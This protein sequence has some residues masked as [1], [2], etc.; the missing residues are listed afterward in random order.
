MDDRLIRTLRAT[1]ETIELSENT[2]C[3]SSN[4]VS[5]N[6]RQKRCFVSTGLNGVLSEFLRK[7]CVEGCVSW[8]TETAELRVLLDYHGIS[9]QQRGRPAMVFN[10]LTAA[11]IPFYLVLAVTVP[12][13]RAQAQSFDFDNGNAAVDIVIANVVPFIFE[14]ISKTAGDATLVLRTTTFLTNAWFDAT[15]P[16]HPTAVGVYSRLGRR[17]SSESQTNRDMNIAVVY[18]SY[19]VLLSLLPNRTQE[20]RQMLEN[21][22]LDPDD[23]RTELTSPVGIG[24]VAGAAIVTGRSR[25]GMNQLGD[26]DGRTF[27]LTP[28]ADYTGYRPLNTAYKLRRPSRWQPDLQVQGLG[29]YKIQQFVTPQYGL[30]E[31]YTYLDPR[32]F[33]VPPPI[34]S[35]VRRFKRY[36]R[37]ADEVLRASAELTEEQKLKAEFFDNKISSLGLSAVFAATSRQLPLLDFIHLDFMVNMAAFDAGIVIWQEKVR[38]DAVRPFSAIRYIYGDIPVKAWGGPFRG[39]VKIPANEWKS[40]LEEA[41]HPEYPSATTC[42]CAAHSQAARLILGDDELGYPVAFSAGTSR[43][44]PGQVPAE[45]TTFVFDTWSEFDHDCGQSR[46]WAGVHFQ[47]AV[48]ESR[49]LCGVFGDLAYAYGQQLISGTAPERQP[50]RRLDLRLN[51]K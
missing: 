23:S 31:P 13:G 20:W 48:D 49:A 11:F 17:P 33:R 4:A 34:N 1:A 41:D 30:V 50:A 19:R 39:T 9:S 36:K 14:D 27:N 15:A 8:R 21:A 18:A 10:K 45:D 7:V 25:D 24:N 12:T 38:F 32:E 29:I 42:F 46:V 2:Q 5:K 44:E 16:Y 40:Y 22:G 37:Q 28:Y 35:N 51:V 6:I 3:M 47:A 43:I 26:E